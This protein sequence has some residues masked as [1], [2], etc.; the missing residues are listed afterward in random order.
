MESAH[1]EFEDRFGSSPD[2][3]QTNAYI[4]YWTLRRL[5]DRFPKSNLFASSRLD[6]PECYATVGKLP[7]LALAIALYRIDW[8]VSMREQGWGVS[9]PSLGPVTSSKLINAVREKSPIRWWYPVCRADDCSEASM[10][11]YLCHSCIQ[12]DWPHVELSP[13]RWLVW[14][15][16]R[17]TEGSN[18]FT[19]WFDCPY[20]LGVVSV[21]LGPSNFMLS[22]LGALQDKLGP[23]AM[24]SVVLSRDVG[25][26]EKF[27][28]DSYSPV[29]P[30]AIFDKRNLYSY[31]DLS[32]QGV[33]RMLAQPDLYAP[34]INA[35]EEDMQK[36]ALSRPHVTDTAEEVPDSFWSDQVDMLL[37]FTPGNVGNRIFG[38]EYQI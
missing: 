33:K 12:E 21:P 28:V 1:T 8:D 2:V 16:V 26:N 11:S 14:K 20:K 18:N 25:V 9:G 10:F 3:G 5:H 32:L 7:T 19:G 6:L 23:L 30:I 4:T 38:Y 31:Y 24:A 15:S 34:T 29:L 27:V 17:R 35:I 36:R 13:E 37:P 22:P